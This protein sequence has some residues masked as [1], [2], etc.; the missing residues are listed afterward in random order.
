MC[1]VLIMMVSIDVYFRTGRLIFYSY[2]GLIILL[3]LYIRG[4]GNDGIGELA[5]ETGRTGIG[6]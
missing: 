2:N 6:A 1:C 4:L 5:R 3:Y